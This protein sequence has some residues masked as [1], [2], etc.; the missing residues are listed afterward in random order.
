VNL[1]PAKWITEGHVLIV[2]R[3]ERYRGETYP[4]HPTQVGNE[5]IHVRGGL[6]L[7]SA[8]AP[9][10]ESV[11]GRYIA[12]D[13]ET[14]KYSPGELPGGYWPFP[15]DGHP[16]R[17][18]YRITGFE[19]REDGTKSI[20]ILRTAWYIMSAGGPDLFRDENYTRD[21]RDRPLKYIIAPGG[22]L[23]DIRQGWIDTRRPGVVG[24]SLPSDPRTVVVVPNADRG[25]SFDFAPGDP[26][27]QPVGPDP[28]IPR[29]LRIRMFDEFPPCMENPAI[30]IV[31]NGMIARQ[32]GIAFHGGPRDLNEIAERKDQQPPY[33]NGLM[34]HSAVGCGIRFRGQVREA[35]L[36]MEQRAGNPQPVAWRHARGTTQVVADPASGDLTVRGG[37]LDLDRPAIV[38]AGLVETAGISA[39]DTAARNLRGIDVT[40]TADERTVD[41]KFAAPEPD[42]RY[43]L[44]VQPNWLTAVAV[45]E[46]RPD[47]FRAEFAEPAP[48]AAKIDWHLIR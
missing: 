8:D 33:V 42:A 5:T 14:E 31:N 20:R 13:D 4:D 18:W 28:W 30:E 37:Q 39:T 36:M 43:A 6:I 22:T 12:V 19:R 21:G 17:R 10:D 47:G 3:N 35:A 16:V 15:D 9:W 34:F 27:V 38:R 46:K 48:S 40:V 44:C 24:L 11:V 41:V 2:R 29:P 32:S 7:G 23:S 45:T 26:V 25:T 1:N